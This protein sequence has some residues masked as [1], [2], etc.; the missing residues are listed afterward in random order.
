MRVVLQEGDI[1]AVAEIAAAVEQFVHF[2]LQALVFFKSLEEG[3]GILLLNGRRVVAGCG[4]IDG[5]RTRNGLIDEFL[6]GVGLRHRGAEC[7][8]PAD[9]ASRLLKGGLPQTS[10]Q[11]VGDPAGA[12]QHLGVISLIALEN[13]A[14]L[15]EGVDG[16]TSH[17]G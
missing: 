7:A 6:F 2:S 15:V 4:V 11:V 13:C 1:G 9:I 5:L 17:A 3:L 8:L 10:L 14:L 16:L 12:A